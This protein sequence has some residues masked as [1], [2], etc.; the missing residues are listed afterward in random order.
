MV[1]FDAARTSSAD[2][3]VADCLLRGKDPRS[4]WGDSGP[5]C[6]GRPL[7][8][9]GDGGDSPAVLRD[10]VC[11]RPVRA[12]R[13]KCGNSTTGENHGRDSR[14]KSQGEPERIA[15]GGARTR[16]VAGSSSRGRRRRAGARALGSRGARVAATGDGSLST[17]TEI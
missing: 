17:S 2:G 12:G 7:R 4:D 10:R 15:R 14:R 5:R 8:R 16:S 3:N 6:D 1:M 11:E 9:T 13:R